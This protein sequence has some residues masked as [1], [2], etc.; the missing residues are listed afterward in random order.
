FLTTGANI[1][2]AVSQAIAIV[3]SILVYV[4]FL[5]AYERYQ[6]KQAAEAAE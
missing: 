4:P 1:M 5:I 2:G 3:V 6:N